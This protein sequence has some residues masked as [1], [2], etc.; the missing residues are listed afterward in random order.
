VDVERS[1]GLAEEIQAALSRLSPFEAWVVRERYGLV[2]GE[3]R[4]I[5]AICM[6]CGLNHRRIEK[7]LESAKDKLSRLLTPPRDGGKSA[8]A[9]RAAA[10]A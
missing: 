1:L 10:T 4:S 8:A 6:D 3:P 7:V 2:T 5:R 9:G